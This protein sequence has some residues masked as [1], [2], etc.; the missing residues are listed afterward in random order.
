MK[1]K[2]IRLGIIFLLFILYVIPGFAH[3]ENREFLRY[4]FIDNTF[5]KQEVLTL[6]DYFQLG[7][8]NEKNQLST[9]DWRTLNLEL[10]KERKQKEIK[11]ESHAIESSRVNQ[12]NSQVPEKGNKVEEPSK[13]IYINQEAF[14]QEVIRLTNIERKKHGLQSLKLD[15]KVAKVARAK[16]KDMA[17]NNYFDHVSPTYGSPFDMLKEF[18][19]I[20]YS[21]GENIARGQTT[22]EEVVKAWM[23]SKGH[24][25]NILHP[26]FTHI[27]VG[28]I[29]KGYYWTQQF[30]KRIDSSV[31]QKT[32]EQRV[33]DLTNQERKKHGLSPLIM[34]SKLA[35]T[36]KAKALDMAKNNYFD[37]I[38]PTYGTPFDMMDQ[39][40]IS[41]QTA[42]E[43]IA[44]GQSTP[45][46]VVQ[47]WMDSEGHKANILN[48]EFT[49]IGVGF[50][51]DNFIWT[52]QFI[53][54]N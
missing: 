42:G 34:N 50:S 12:K 6:D 16:S 29:G 3:A 48:P 51:K 36:A 38:S 33:I 14:E 19:V 28:F 10:L 43:N 9:I 52:Q 11:K 37:H 49:H 4:Y 21:A 7:M 35:D 27:G 5:Y 17:S 30:I 54:Q 41:Y 47:T 18:G 23:D 25:E 32:F 15:E 45:E 8:F 39:F 1:Q 22:P 20:Y 2:I 13:K 31:S 24:R 46:Q 44:K 53:G 40:G 26:D